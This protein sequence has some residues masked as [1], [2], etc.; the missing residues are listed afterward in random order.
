[1]KTAINSLTILWLYIRHLL[2]ITPVEIREIQVSREIIGGK[3]RTRIQWRIRGCHRISVSGYR[4]QPGNIKGVIINEL[5]Q[6][7][8]LNIRFFGC[9]GVLDYS[10]EVPATDIQFFMQF[11]S[12][13]EIPDMSAVQEI[14]PVIFNTQSKIPAVQPRIYLL[15]I[16]F[17]LE[18][19]SLHPEQNQ[20]STKM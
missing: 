4:D 3:T 12:S 16:V 14:R 10:V 20:S 1:M 6:S 8:V 15:P 17:D 9:H 19:H 5:G 11:K 13:T 2:T 7:Q 18:T